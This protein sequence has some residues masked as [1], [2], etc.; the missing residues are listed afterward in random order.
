MLYDF[1][2][3]AQKIKNENKNRAVNVMPFHKKPT[4][5]NGYAGSN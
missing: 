5:N 2:G 4:K 3:I 1:C